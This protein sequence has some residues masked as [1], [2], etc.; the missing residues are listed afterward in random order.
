[1]PGPQAA[2]GSF[3]F[4]RFRP[5]EFAASECVERKPA[6]SSSA[7]ASVTIANTPATT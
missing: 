1:M 6:G 3:V 5:I 2:G 4:G 7:A